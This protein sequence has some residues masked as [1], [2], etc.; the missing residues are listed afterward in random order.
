MKHKTIMQ[1]TGDEDLKWDRGREKVKKTEY[2]SQCKKKKKASAERIERICPLVGWERSEV[3]KS[4]N[5]R[6][7]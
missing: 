5:L 6:G 3:S 1:A 7:L 2:K 4:I